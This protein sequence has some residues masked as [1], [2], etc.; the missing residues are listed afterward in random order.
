MGRWLI[1][2]AKAFKLWLAH[3]GDDNCQ[4]TG[5]VTA[6]NPWSWCW[7]CRLW[8]KQMNLR[9]GAKFQIL[10]ETVFGHDYWQIVNVWAN[11]CCRLN[12]SVC[13]VYAVGTFLNA[14]MKLSWSVQKKIIVNACDSKYVWM[15]EWNMFFFCFYVSCIFVATYQNAVTWHAPVIH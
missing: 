4:T 9:R 15:R 11:I 5:G 2:A 1:W 6:P 7:L 3:I 13:G 14:D 10:I 12:F 8:T